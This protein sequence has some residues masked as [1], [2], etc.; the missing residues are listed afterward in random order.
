MKYTVHG[1]VG[2]LVFSLGLAVGIYVP[3]FN[4]GKNPVESIVPRQPVSESARQYI[5]VTKKKSYFALDSDGNLIPELRQGR[6]YYKK[7]ES[8]YSYKRMLVSNRSAVVVMDPWLDSGDATLNEF[9]K[10]V[11]DNKVLPL[12]IKAVGFGMPVF[13]LTN[14]PKKFQA[15]YGSQVDPRLENLAKEYPGKVRILFHQ[16]FDEDSFAGF[17]KEQSIDTLIYSGFASNM[18]VIGRAMGMV[19][20]QTKGF[21]LFFIPQASAAVEFGDSWETAEVHVAT[22]SLISQWV[23]EIID[24]GDFLSLEPNAK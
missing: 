20:M 13:I 10:P 19:P 14:D 9:F 7:G 6:R 23:G 5:V 12:V 17:L 3:Q 16:D 22:T 4:Q 24:L 2:A 8:E 1:I 15:D 21:R 11:M 18:C